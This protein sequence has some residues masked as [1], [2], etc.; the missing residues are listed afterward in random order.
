MCHF[1]KRKIRGLIKSK[2]QEQFPIVKNAPAFHVM[3]FDLL[4]IAVYFVDCLRK[5]KRAV[6]FS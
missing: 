5:S 1:F 6:V 3:L 4:E 2:K